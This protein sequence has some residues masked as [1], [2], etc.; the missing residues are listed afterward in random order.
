MVIMD[1]VGRSNLDMA[2]RAGHGLQLPMYDLRLACMVN[3]NCLPNKPLFP[4]LAAVQTLWHSRSPESFGFSWQEVAMA[5]D[6][7][8]RLGA[9]AEGDVAAPTLLPC[10]DGEERACQP[11][12]EDDEGTQSSCTLLLSVCLHACTQLAKYRVRCS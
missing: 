3:E 7:M 8:E 12:Q 6:H 9:T 5:D 1:F 4:K 11:E 10:D 2:A